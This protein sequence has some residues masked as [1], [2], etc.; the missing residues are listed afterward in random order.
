MQRRLFIVIGI[1]LAVLAVLGVAYVILN[2][3]GGISPISPGQP[4]GVESGTPT[5]EV[6]P[7][8][9][10]IVARQ[11]IPRG[12]EFPPGS[13][14]R[15]NFPATQRPENAI[16]NEAETVGQVARIEIA[17]GQIILRDY[18]RPRAGGSSSD[19]AFET[20]AG[21]VLVAFPV[22]R[23][24]S[25]AYA[26]QA[27][28]FVDVLMTVSFVDIDP[29]FQ[30]ILPNKFSFINSEPIIVAEEV[31]GS[32]ITIDSSKATDEGR[33]SIENADF[34]GFEYP[35][36]PQR[37]R[38]VAQLTVQGAKVVR[39]GSWLP[40]P[41]PA[42]AE[43]GAPP[44]T[45]A[46]P[47]IVSLAVTPQDALVLLWARQTQAR[48]ELA[49]RAAGDENARHG[50]EAV[51]LQYMLTRFNIAVPPKLEFAIEKSDILNPTPTPLPPPPASQ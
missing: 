25:V 12:S 14:G 35:S 4:E 38:R 9:E 34:P 13:L 50:T 37:P 16:T 15:I 47:N 43:E 11:P 40:E 26:V 10:V 51:T 6:I 41:T 44:P 48:M 24:S 8:V 36:E 2:Q 27:G 31:V 20:P 28:D 1:V 33:L 22:D 49:L 19:A 7:T 39:V 45:P 42:P 3:G 5:E 23:Q 46:P 30:T 29:E 21:R 18:L 32:Q 17:Q